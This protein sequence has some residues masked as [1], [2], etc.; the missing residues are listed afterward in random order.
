MPYWLLMVLV[1]LIF[2]GGTG[3]TQKLATNHLSSR[4]TFV[5]Y[6]MAFIPVSSGLL[7]AS[8][9]KWDYPIGTMALALSGGLLLGLATL[10]LFVALERGGKASIVVPLVALYP[11]LTVLLAL[12]FLGEQLVGRQWLGIFFAIVAGVLL[13]QE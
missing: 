9:V 8:Q 6:A 3:I 13:S 10:P 7:Y 2:W 5:W 1:T 4:L 11:L 12:V